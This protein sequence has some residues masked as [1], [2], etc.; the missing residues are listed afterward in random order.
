M[1]KG[2]GR[3]PAVVS[4]KVYADR[5]EKAFGKVPAP[6]REAAEAPKQGFALLLG[7]GYTEIPESDHLPGGAFHE[8]KTDE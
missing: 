4:D 6:P 8:E 5:W 2:D 3:R 7:D 1:G